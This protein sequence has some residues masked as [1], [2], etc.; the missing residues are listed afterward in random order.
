LRKKTLFTIF[1]AVCLAIF[2][3]GTVQAASTLPPVPQ[4]FYGHLAINGVAAPAGTQVKA[5][6]EGV[7]Y[8]AY[9]P[10]ITEQTGKYGAED[11]WV[12]APLVVQG[13]N[14]G[15]TLT[16]YVNGVSTGQTTAFVPGGQT[17]LDLNVTIEQPAPAPPGPTPGPTPT[18]TPTPTPEPTPTPT[19][20]P[21]PTPTPEPTPTPTPEPTPTP[22]PE[23]TPPTPEPT[24]TT[25]APEPTP[26]P[27]PSAPV[28][29]GTST[30]WYVVGGI[31]FGV[32]VIGG[33]FVISRVRRS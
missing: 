33:W 12:G 2:S 29:P 5:V 25:P 17:R 9:N 31:L 26:E 6:G 13:K 18:P 27:T 14:P 4:L 30:L 1:A 15:S 11:L 20:E 8:D 3:A 16:F 28:E 32:I 23:P 7:I 22:T 24:S 10:V 21:T 19:P